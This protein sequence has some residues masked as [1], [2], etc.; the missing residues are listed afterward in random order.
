MS[1]FNFLNYSFYIKGFTAVFT[2]FFFFEGMAFALTLGL[3]I[4][5]YLFRK[6]RVSSSKLRGVDRSILL[7]PVSGVVLSQTGDSANSNITFKIPFW[8]YYG[9]N[10]P[11]AGAV[12]SYLESSESYK[13]AGIIPVTATKKQILF[14]SKELG[15][16][17]LTVLDR[18]FLFP[19][20]LW[21]RSGDI[22]SMGAVVGYLPFGGKVVIEFSNKLNILVKLGDDVS[23]SRALIASK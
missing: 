3:I 14:D 22:V 12:L 1:K 23:S 18:Y 9:I 11:V 16:I 13:I 19:G 15:R 4:L 21:A 5:L 6:D 7:A 8:K 20:K 2:T 17:K 10:A